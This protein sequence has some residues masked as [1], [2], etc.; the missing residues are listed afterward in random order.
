MKIYNSTYTPN[1]LSPSNTLSA[2][3]AS[4]K[5]SLPL[6]RTPSYFDLNHSKAFET[7]EKRE[8]TISKANANGGVLVCL[9]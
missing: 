4:G 8:R 5:T 3:L 1:G 2:L 6:N 7:S 9:I